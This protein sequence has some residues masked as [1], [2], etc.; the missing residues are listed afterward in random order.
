MVADVVGVGGEEQ[1]DAYRVEAQIAVGD[2]C[3]GHQQDQRSQDGVAYSEQQFD[4]DLGQNDPE[5]FQWM[6]GT[7]VD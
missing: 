5:Q 3:L 7:G 1:A 2:G 4:D 6:V